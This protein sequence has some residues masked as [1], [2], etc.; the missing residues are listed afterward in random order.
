MA[1]AN[2]E[3][4]LNWKLG[5]LVDAEG[6]HVAVERRKAELM[7]EWITTSELNLAP[8]SPTNRYLSFAIRMS[9]TSSFVERFPAL[10]ERSTEFKGSSELRSLPTLRYPALLRAALAADPTNRQ[11]RPSDGYDIE[12][13]TIG[14]SRC[15]VVTADGSMTRIARERNLIPDGCQLFEFTDVA[16]LTAVVE[17]ALQY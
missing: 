1:E 10:L 5:P 16:G 2:T 9:Q 11:P 6:F 17:Q 7:A 12:H 14:L 15:D 4:M 3:A 13:V 8:G